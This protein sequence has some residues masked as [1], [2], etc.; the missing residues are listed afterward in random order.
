LEAAQVS[1]ADVPL[2]VGTLGKAFGCFGAFVAG[3][4]D[5]IE[6]ILQRARSYI[7]TTALPPG[8]AAAARV[9]VQIA[10]EESWRRQRL[11]ILISRFRAGA[12]QLGLSLMPS[13][14]PIQPL[15][16]GDAARCVAVSDALRMA[17]FWVTPIRAPT[18]PAGSERLRITLSAAH[19]EAE[20]DS[21]LAALA[22]VFR[23]P[24]GA[25][26]ASMSPSGS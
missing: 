6:L 18:V 20:V 26:T 24:H 9:G 16:I 15:L 19:E 14:T 11:T 5:L 8:I 7:Y 17:G 22:E 4:R 13:T 25:D 12:K 23:A 3:D 2:L 1:S 21:L 10:A